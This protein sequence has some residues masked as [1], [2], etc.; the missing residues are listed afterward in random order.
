[1]RFRKID[2]IIFYIL[3]EIIYIINWMGPVAIKE[4]LTIAFAPIFQVLIYGT[5]TNLVFRRR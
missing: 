5:I 4:I 2:Y 3:C 1:M